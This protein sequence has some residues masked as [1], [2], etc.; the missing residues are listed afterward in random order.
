MNKLSEKQYRR[1]LTC[2]SN[3][4]ENGCINWKGYGVNGYGTFYFNGKSVKAHRLAYS[5]RY[6]EIEKGK[7]IMED[8][9]PV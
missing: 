4:D 7:L 1:F 9:Y 8:I 2:I 6:G 3:K 5:S